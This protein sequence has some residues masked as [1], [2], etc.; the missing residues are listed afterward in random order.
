MKR[1]DQL[2]I[3]IFADGADLPTM[4]ALNENPLI[5]G[6][7]TNPSLMHRAGIKDYGGF[8]KDAEGFIL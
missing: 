6:L 4:L 3:K 1:L 7:T 8:A 5:R 2:R